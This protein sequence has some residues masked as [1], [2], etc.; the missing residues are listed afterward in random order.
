MAWIPDHYRIVL[1]VDRDRDDCQELKAKLEKICASAGFRSRRASQDSS[2]QVATRIVI[3]EIE[4]WYF[5]DWQAV[6]EAYPRV[7][8]KVPYK[9]AYRDPD[10]IKGGTKEAFERVLRQNGY[11]QQGLANV[12]AAQDI[13]RHMDSSRNRSRSFCVF[14][15]AIAE[16]VSVK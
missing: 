1:V 8:P 3:E 15:D 10:A 5:G 2:W 14:R 7:S 11:F 4:A 16:A 9:A 6:R 13:G 12:R